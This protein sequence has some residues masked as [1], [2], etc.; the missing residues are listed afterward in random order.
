MGI[1]RNLLR[2]L[3]VLFAFAMVAAAC[4]SSDDDDSSS[5]SS[6]S[7][8]ATAE[9]H[10]DD[11]GEEED[12][13][14]TLSQDAVE[15]AVSGDSDD[16]G[17]AAEEASDCPQDRSTVEGIFAEADCNRDAIIA[18][19]TAKM[20]AG[21]WG[22]NSDNHLIGPSGMEIDLNECPADW[23]DKAGLT[24]DQLRFGQTTVQSGNLAAYGNLSLGMQIYF[25]YVNS[26]DVL[27]GR[28]IEFIIKDDGYVAA[29]TIEYVDELIESANVH[30]LQGLGSP[31]GLAVYDKIN[32]E[33]IP[34]PFYLSG[35]P[36]WGDPEIHPWTTSRQMSYSTEAM[37]WGTWIKV[38]LADQLPVSVAG[39][40]MDNDFG[41]AY[42]MGFEAYAEQNPDVVEEYLP[43]RHDPAAP[44]LTNEVTT[45]AAF[46]P[47]VFI[48]MTAGNP[49]LLAIQEVES[50]GL[51]DR[52]EAAFTPSVCKGIAAY[53][54][55]AGMAADD[56][57][58]VGGGL[59]DTTDPGKMDEP[60]I[61]F[62]RDMIS[63]AGEDPG[64][65]LTGDGA[66]RGLE[67]TEAFRIADALPGGM[68]RTNLMLALRNFKI[69][70]PCV[71]DG[72]Q[73]ELNGNADAYYIEGSDF[74]Q[75]DA[76]QQTWNQIG[77]VVDANGGTPNCRWDKANGGCR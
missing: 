8:S 71:M 49:C 44:T 55:P 59:K 31:N 67:F 4:G 33:C 50:S 5:S 27:S 53:L 18:M 15:K 30:L 16:A 32:A 47:D 14:G 72:I 3:A 57:W 29:Q 9:D 58:V 64:I 19:I 11:H 70:N 74:S 46:D 23:D 25:D 42:E 35:H 76:E 69:Y 60:F 24:D 10:G 66:C 56:W 21:E 77:D 12:T 68:S 37:L 63:D 75:F 52:I 51:L 26:L 2:L 17:D 13:G 48:S 28:D 1:R 6:E 62:V 65:S 54:A 73:T 36:A 38:N 7:A 43:V 61:K 41:L 39:L 20:D 22:V 34:H 40:V 45:I